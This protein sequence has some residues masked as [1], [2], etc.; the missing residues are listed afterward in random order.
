MQR[1]GLHE[2]RSS[3]DPVALSVNH[4]AAASL[5]HIITQ[6]PDANRYAVK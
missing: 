1:T 2:V 3:P 6:D 5:T 4:L